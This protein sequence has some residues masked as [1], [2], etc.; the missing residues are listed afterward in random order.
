MVGDHVVQFARDALALLEQRALA[1]VPEL[2][3]LELALAAAPLPDDGAEQQRD[4]RPGRRPRRVDPGSRNAAPA[5]VAAVAAIMIRGR[6]R[7]A[8]AYRHR[9]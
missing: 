9:P 5:T 3:L 1:G 6:Q 8:T 7:T 4:W 2:L